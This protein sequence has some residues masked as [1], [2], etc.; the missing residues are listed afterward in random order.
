M[1]E[2]PLVSIVVVTYDSERVIGACLESV[3]GQTFSRL[4]VVVIDN[5]SNDRT[6]EVLRSCKTPFRFVKNETN[7]GFAA[8]QNQGIRLTRGAYYLALN[9]DV[10]MRADFI[11]ELVKAAEM[12]PR[13][14][15]VTGKL[16]RKDLGDGATLID[17]TG[18]YMI[19][20]LRHLD[21]GAGEPD[22]GQYGRRQFVFGASGAAAFYRRSMLEDV[23]V[24]GETFDE[25]FFAFREDADLAW[26]AQLLGWGCLYTPDAVATHERRVLPDRRASLPAA[27]NMHSV[28]NRFLL[29]LKN[30]TVLEFV[31][32]FLPSVLRD[33]Q[34]VGYVVLK[35]RSSLPGLWFVARNLGR[36]WRKRRK[37]MSAR[38]A[39]CRE[40]LR[41]FRRRP[42][43][44]EV[45]DL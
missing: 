35:E 15:S 10:E 20:S 32:L 9:P 16:L 24:A 2:R 30:Q 8:A 34:V 22:R 33:I 4:E 5:D 36:I 25:D 26:R 37:I 12:D 17:S 28:K 38:K 40:M 45:G 31:A 11:E 6:E 1:S 27:I 41:W 19:P 39:S 7:R 14:G 3:A 42:V 44:F 43:A 18:V 21:R 13:V 23:A 29:R